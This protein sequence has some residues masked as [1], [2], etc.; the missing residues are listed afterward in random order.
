[1][2]VLKLAHEGRL[3][4]RKVRALPL[5]SEADGAK[6]YACPAT[7]LAAGVPVIVGGVVDGGVLCAAVTVIRKG[8]T[9][10]TPTLSETLISISFVVPT[11]S[12][13]GVPL[14]SPVAV[15]NVAQPGMLVML[16]VSAVLRVSDTVGV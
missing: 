8:P 15:L 7:T 14:S 6:E 5:R 12:A 16:N 3:T 11:S 4:I 2:L 10:A 9:V 13:P 1:V